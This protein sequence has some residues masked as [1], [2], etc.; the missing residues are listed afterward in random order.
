MAWKARGEYER[1]LDDLSEAI[2]LFHGRFALALYD[3]GN[4]YLAMGELQSAGTD[5]AAVLDLDSNHS[6]ALYGAGLVLKELG[7]FELALELYDAALALEPENASYLN[8]RGAAWLALGA[9]EQALIDFTW[10]IELDPSYPFPRLNRAHV[11]LF[12][13]NEELAL[14]AYADAIS[15]SPHDPL[16]AQK[17]AMALYQ[18][19]AMLEVALEYIG[20]AIQID[21]SD[22]RSHLIEARILVSLERPENVKLSLSRSPRIL[23][24][25]D[26]KEVQTMLIS[27]GHYDGPID[28]IYSSDMQEAME[29][30]V[31][32][33]G[34][35]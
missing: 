31:Y 25:A 1:A 14:E 6:D 28:G 5:Y 9:Y 4:T 11:F 21:P 17:V 10:S 34:C 35:L 24:D 32:D 16:I 12:E 13:G 7:N 2:E 18:A 15:L 22:S 27:T 3:R 33:N 19:D 29:R 8:G 26:I 20:R 23:D 30:C